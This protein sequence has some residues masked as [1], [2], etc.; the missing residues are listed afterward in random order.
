MYDERGYNEQGYNRNDYDRLGYNSRGF[1]KAGYHRVTNN[2]YDRF[3]YDVEGYDL[4][5]FNEAGINKNGKTRQQIENEK[6]IELKKVDADKKIINDVFTSSEE[7]FENIVEK[8]SFD[9]NIEIAPQ[10]KRTARIISGVKQWP[11]DPSISKTAIYLSNYKCQYDSEHTTFTSGTTKQQ[12]MEAHHFIPMNAQ[13][14]FKNS[15]DVLGNVVSLC[16]TC[17]RMIH[18]VDEKSKNK[19]IDKLFLGK[20][21]ELKKY[22]LEISLE[23]IK[24]LY[25]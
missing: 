4:E 15:L 17:H 16:P 10:R 6:I 25:K 12:Y 19:I 9:L 18:H 21:E 2:L 13:E 3:G 23:E 22:G 1:S 14:R 11:R 7:E 24:N 8:A 20:I 5:G